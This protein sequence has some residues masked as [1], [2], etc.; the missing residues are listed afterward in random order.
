MKHLTLL[1]TALF[2]SALPLTANALDNIESYYELTTE[3]LTEHAALGDPYALYILAE[4]YDHGYENTQ[5]NDAE[6]E[7]LFREAVNGFK[8]RARA[9]DAPSMLFLGR[10]YEKGQGLPENTGKA[11]GYYVQAAELGDD[12]A[13]DL[14]KQALNV[15]DAALCEWVQ[16]HKVEAPQICAE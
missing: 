13:F 10:M 2:F 1:L 4:R 6:A 15:D 3:K 7:R 5:E 12:Q 14:I 9:D 8:I 16:K 11:L